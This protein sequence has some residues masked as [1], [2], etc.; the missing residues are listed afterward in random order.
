[1]PYPLQSQHPSLRQEA[2]QKELSC[3]RDALATSNGNKSRAAE[4]LNC[5]RMTLYRKM[6][7]YGLVAN[8]RKSA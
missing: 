7:K 8:S 1:L 2:D 4:Q 6:A 5:S 3:L